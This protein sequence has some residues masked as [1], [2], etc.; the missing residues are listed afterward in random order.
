MAGRVPRWLL[1]CGIGC[2]VVILVGAGL[3]VGSVLFFRNALQDFERADQTME[4]VEER[5]G[6][7]ETFRPQPDGAIP[8]QRM[9]AFL[10]VR[11]RSAPARENLDRSLS[12]LSGRPGETPTRIGGL[13]RLVAGGRLL[14]QLAAFVDQRNEALLEAEMGLGEYYYL[15]TLTYYSWLGKPLDDGPSFKLVGENGY[16]LETIENIDESVVRDYRI[17]QVRGSL[18]RLLLPVLRNQ[19]SDL[20]GG[21]LDRDWADVLSAEMAAM[22]ANP[23]R[24]PWEDGLPQLIASSLEPYRGRLQESYSPMCNALEAGLARR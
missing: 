16:V 22:E 17:E 12:A 23:R 20:A 2:G 21:G 13:R 19:R 5:Y 24:L 18:N 4:T 8:P 6:P 14:H 9:D 10:A 11:E 15:Y 7:I 3:I 1:G